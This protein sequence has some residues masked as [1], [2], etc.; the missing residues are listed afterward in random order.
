MATALEKL[1]EYATRLEAANTSLE[2]KMLLI[3]EQLA[4]SVSEAEIISVLEAPVS[5]I[6]TKINEINPEQ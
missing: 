4:N 2:A 3:N 5:S 1:Q 6:E